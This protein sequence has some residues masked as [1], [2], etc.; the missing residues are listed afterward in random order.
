MSIVRALRYGQVTLPKKFRE[1]LNIK[2]GDLLEAKL[3]DQKIVLTP[4]VLL[5]KDRAWEQVFQV[6]EDVHEKNKHIPQE[7]AE[8]DALELI[9]EF[10]RRQD[11]RNPS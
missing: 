6:L 11:A 9:K 4:K 7:E 2:E 10:R 1:V 3:E 5:N 8:R